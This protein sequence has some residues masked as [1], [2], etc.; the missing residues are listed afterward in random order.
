MQATLLGIAGAIILALLAALVGPQ[1]VDWTSYRATIESEATRYFQFGNQQDWR[2]PEILADAT[3]E[4]C[5]APLDR[6]CGRAFYDE[7][8]LR[9]LRGTADFSAYSAVPGTT[10]APF[11]REM[12]E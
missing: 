8:A 11:C 3:V 5:C 4:I 10:P 6:V 2:T 1:F 12:V 9:E 7:E